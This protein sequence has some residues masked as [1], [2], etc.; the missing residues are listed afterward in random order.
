M[1]E[2][3]A[4]QTNRGI[5]LTLGDVLFDT[6]KS[7]LKAGAMRPI[8]QIA[9]FLQ[10]N[11]E[12]RVQIEGFTDSVGTDEFNMQLSQQRADSVAMAILQ[13]G[14]SAER[15]RAMGYG[16][17]FPKASNDSPGSRQLNR[18]V[19]IIV[20][21]GDADIPGRTAGNP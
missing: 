10:E 17:G 15:V 2:L 7:Q 4:A 11:P 9:S 19:E 14:I 21:N 3:Q 8:E 13:R 6:G 12:R 1:G 18:R 20:S 16:E 5:V